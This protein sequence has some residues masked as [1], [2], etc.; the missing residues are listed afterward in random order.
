M[1]IFELA[2]QKQFDE[3]QR[4]L[5]RACSRFGEDVILARMRIWLQELGDEYRK[6]KR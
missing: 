3:A 1:H 4:E 5:E 6:V 2:Y